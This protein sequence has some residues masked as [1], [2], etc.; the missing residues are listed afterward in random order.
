V[1]SSTS[2]SESDTETLETTSYGSSPSSATLTEDRTTTPSA[3]I[4]YGNLTALSTS[5]SAAPTTPTVEVVLSAAGNMIGNNVG[6]V[7]A[8]GFGALWI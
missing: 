4:T 2:I 6:A 3:T 1:T 7:V 5:Y 8:L